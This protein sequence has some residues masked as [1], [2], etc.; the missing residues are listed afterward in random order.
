MILCF[1][2]RENMANVAQRTANLNGT[3]QKQ[4]REREGKKERMRDESTGS[5]W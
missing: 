3:S 4:E 1:V 5:L 2:F